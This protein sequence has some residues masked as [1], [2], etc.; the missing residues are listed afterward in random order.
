MSETKTA[1]IVNGTDHAAASAWI[2]PGRQIARM[3]DADMC[4][5]DGLAELQRAADLVTL[6]SLPDGYAVRMWN[7]RGESTVA[8][9][10]RSGPTIAFIGPTAIA[11]AAAW[12]REVAG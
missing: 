12:C 4:S 6:A 10:E 3:V 5:P 1:Y 2:A 7:Y 8:I 9:D 11:E